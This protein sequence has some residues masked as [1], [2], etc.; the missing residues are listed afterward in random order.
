MKKGQHLSYGHL[1]SRAVLLFSKHHG[2]M[3]KID[4]HICVCLHCNISGILIL[5]DIIQDY[6]RVRKN[7]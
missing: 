7:I 5:E 2:V 6:L 1:L 4:K 3:G